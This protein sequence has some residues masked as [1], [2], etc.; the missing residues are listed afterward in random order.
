[1]GVAVLPGSGLV[2]G[3][4]AR[5]SWVAQALPAVWAVPVPGTGRVSAGRL[6]EVLANRGDDEPQRSPVVR[7]CARV[8]VLGAAGADGHA[9]DV[10][11]RAPRLHAWVGTGGHNDVVVLPAFAHVEGN[12][13]D[14]AGDDPGCGEDFFADLD[15]KF[16]GSSA[17]FTLVLLV[18]GAQLVSDLRER[19]HGLAPADLASARTQLAPAPLP[20]VWVASGLLVAV[21]LALGGGVH[22]AQVPRHQ[23]EKGAAHGTPFGPLL[24]EPLT[25]LEPLR[26]G[27][28]V[29]HRSPPTRRTCRGRRVRSR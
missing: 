6:F 8:D 21:A 18:G 14:G 16:G 26:W 11:R 13:A 20:V 10:V 17:E 4:R 23:L 3:R 12:A 19:L 29:S 7:W 2:I 24:W 25:S 22:V 1:M 27:R 28:V 9:V 5:D 15:T